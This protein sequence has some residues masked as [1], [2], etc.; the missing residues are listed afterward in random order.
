MAEKD[1][2]KDEKEKTGG[3]GENKTLT[4][5]DPYD[6]RRIYEEMEL[7]LVLSLQRNLKRHMR[8]E[9]RLGFAWEQWQK[10]ALRD[11]DSFRRE[12]L[13][14]I[15]DFEDDIQKQV[16]EV[17]KG[18][19]EYGF[20]YTRVSAEDNLGISFPEDGKLTADLG[21]EPKPETDFFRS[22]PR[23]LNA[24]ADAVK[25]DL[26]T[27]N[28]AIYRKMDD[29]YRQTVFSATYKMSSG[30]LTLQQAVDEAVKELLKNGIRCIR[31]S[32]GATVDVVSYV[33]MA[34]RT[35]S[36][37]ARMLGEG[38]FRDRHQ[39]WL[40]R[41]S[42]HTATCEKCY[43]WQGKILIDDV[44]SHPTDEFLEENDE[45]YEL[46]SSAIEAGLFHP[47]C[48]HILYTYYPNTREPVIKSAEESKR[49]YQIEQKMR[50]LEREIRAYKRDA[51]AAIDP[52]NKDKAK[53]ALRKSQAELRKLLKDNPEFK[54]NA[55]RERAN[56]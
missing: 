55:W 13:R 10:A 28:N 12:T 39:M 50:R 18:T 11:I 17:L 23:K 33:E 36:Q 15:D 43:P 4:Q 3:E 26:A 20:E 45:S 22:N 2:A 34:I 49:L 35:A 51:A 30:V 44:Y 52:A 19:Y 53:Q 56:V 37:R 31:Y 32:N 38:Q 7:Y 24:L 54:R 40:V 27:A 48:R 41:V 29:I 8:E 47:N 21:N 6:L 1:R 14:I 9:E 16:D 25:L 5:P 46:V 42:N